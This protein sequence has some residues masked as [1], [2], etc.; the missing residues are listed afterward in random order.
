MTHLVKWPKFKALT[1]SNAAED[2]EPW[3]FS[4]GAGGNAEWHSHFGVQVGSFLQNYTYSYLMA[5]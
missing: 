4:L 3:E 5:Q 2:V 1:S